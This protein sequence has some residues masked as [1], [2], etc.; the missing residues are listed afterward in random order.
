MLGQFAINWKRMQEVDFLTPMFYKY[1]Q[2][3][4]T[5]P[6]RVDSYFTIFLPFKERVWLVLGIM[7]IMATFTICMIFQS[8]FGFRSDLLL[9]SISSAASP[10]INAPVAHFWSGNAKLFFSIYFPMCLIINWAYKTNLLA[11]LVIIE[12]EPEVNTAADVLN[13]GL[14]VYVQEHTYVE[15]FLRQT[16]DKKLKKI[17]MQSLENNRTYSRREPKLFK[18]AITELQEGV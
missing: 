6:K 17:W 5:F 4:H 13:S 3:I 15:D 11:S 8:K 7:F 16:S 12:Y 1:I 9:H 18:H 2:V 14:P 10:I